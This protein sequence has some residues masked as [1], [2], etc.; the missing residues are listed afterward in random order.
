MS[1]RRRITDHIAD[2]KPYNPEGSDEDSEDYSPRAAR[3]SA[4]R[5]ENGAVEKKTR[6]KATERPQVCFNAEHTLYSC[7]GHVKMSKLLLTRM[8]WW[9]DLTTN[10][11]K[12]TYGPFNGISYL[13][14]ITPQGADQIR[15]TFSKRKKGMV[16]KAAQLSALSKAKVG[17]DA[18][19]DVLYLHCS[20]TMVSA[21]VCLAPV[22]IMYN[23]K[24]IFG[25]CSSIAVTFQA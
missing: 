10:A 6:R 25:E 2:D 15:Q 22:R 19:M 14:Y 7:A 4:G 23:P 1:K 12:L 16:L 24:T 3:R 20:M 8:L 21:L 11:N 18:V 13:P 17:F 9:H 5:G